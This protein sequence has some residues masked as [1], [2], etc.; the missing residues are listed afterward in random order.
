MANNRGLVYI[1]P[2]VVEI[3]NIDFPK[4]IG[5]AGRKCDH[6]VIHKSVAMNICGID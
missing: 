4:L 2:G 3:Q 5:P 1:G 6:G